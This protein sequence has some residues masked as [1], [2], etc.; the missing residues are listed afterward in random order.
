MNPMSPISPPS[1]LVHQQR[2][3]HAEM[4]AE[5]EAAGFKVLMPFSSRDD[6]TPEGGMPPGDLKSLMVV[7]FE[8]TG[9][10]AAKDVPIEIGFIRVE[11]HPESGTIGRVLERYSAL[12]DCGHE[13]DPEV[14][15][16]TNLTRSMLVGHR[17]DDERVN[18]AIEA[19]D[20]CIA[21]NANYDR[22]MGEKRFPAFAKKAWACSMVE[23]PWDE[24]N[25]G[26][27]KQ[28]F[29]AFRVANMHYGAHRA[30][31]DCEALLQILLSDS[32]DGHN[33]FKHVLDN[34]SK[35]TRTVWAEKAPFDKKDILKNDGGYRWSAE[36]PGKIAKTWHKERVTD[37]ESELA[38][39]YPVYGYPAFVTV[40]T[41]T[42][43]E[44][45]SGRFMAREKIK[46]DAPAAQATIQ[47]AKTPTTTTS[48]QPHAVP[49][50]EQKR[51]APLVFAASQQGTRAPQADLFG[52][53]DRATPAGSPESTQASPSP[54]PP[55]GWVDPMP[56]GHQNKPASRGFRFRR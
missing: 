17:F 6:Y 56:D 1:A 33:C 27:K 38:F 22:T 8:A 19:S 25:V 45:Y 7:D 3:R 18:A 50:A 53:A 4:I 16:V 29:L 5:L 44:R 28:E 51:P 32:H 2:D 13:L 15:R 12:E 55:P 34:A 11:F 41:M 23:G 42:A 31:S 37:L 35:P 30:M 39:L 20:L 36:D 14:E 43:L 10:D 40:D 26:S 48:A 24:M 46:L 54:Q 9:K 52:S 47:T 21:H 49:V